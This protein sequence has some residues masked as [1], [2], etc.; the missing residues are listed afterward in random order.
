MEVI[1]KKIRIEVS[2]DGYDAYVIADDPDL[3]PS[4]VQAALEANGI[5]Y[6]LEANAA[7]EA[8]NN[9]GTR[10]LAASGVRHT[11]GS[12][13]WFERIRNREETEA[14][15]KFE[16]TNV[17]A[18]EIFGVIHKPTPGTVGID[19]YG[20]KIN[21]KP[22]MQIN[23]FTGSN[24]KR[25]ESEDK[26][27]LEALIDGN[28]KIRNASVEIHPELIVSNDIDYSDGEFEFAG[29]LRISGDIKGSSTLKV[30]HNVVVFGSVE[31]VRIIAGGNVAIK[32]SF[33]GRGDGLIK[34]GGN[35]ELYVVLN[36]IIEAGG[37][38][39]ITKESVNARL[40][41]V[42][43]VLAHKAIIMGGIV[44]A[45]EKIEVMTLG[46]ELYSTTKVKLGLRELL[47]EEMRT[48]DKEIELQ[49][50][51]T[52]ALKNEIYFLVRDRIEGKDF[53]AEKANQLK[54]LQNKLQQQNEIIRLLNEKKQETSV[55]ANRKR[56][57][58]LT[59]FGIIHQSVVS[60]I[61]G[62]RFALKQSYRN[63][64]F[65]EVKSE[66][67]HTKNFE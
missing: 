26:I 37:S 9:I 55:E 41:A 47:T 6:G 61:N 21:P 52:E 11:D 17:Y 38:I 32:G 23:V 51:V 40:I 46:G 59:V 29:S 5:A 22:G 24:I 64:T 57:P 49:T 42:N 44:T 10:V 33:V 13:G 66:I 28:L 18:G 53:T 39:S 3:Q 67:I 34:A 62:V 19:V 1:A 12:N 43:S 45:G 63:V 7:N 48:V 8:V 60:E 65:E 54:L 58:K 56:S 27:T 30:K 50:K 20:K 4:D 2:K 31:D 35:V 25:A 14:E 15:K 36:Q 16:F